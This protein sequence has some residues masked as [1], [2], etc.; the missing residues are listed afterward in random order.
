MAKRFSS[1]VLFSMLPLMAAQSSAA[2][3]PNQPYGEGGELN[4]HRAGVVYS[5]PGGREVAPAGLGFWLLTKS[6][7]VWFRIDDVPYGQAFPHGFSYAGRPILH[8]SDGADWRSP[9]GMAV[10]PIRWGDHVGGGWGHG[11]EGT[12]FYLSIW[13]RWSL[14]H[15]AFAHPE[16]FELHYRPPRRQASDVG[17][18]R[19]AT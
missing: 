9:R 11:P 10:R 2:L 16:R 17:S 18:G 1:L 3:V 4:R 6:K 5:T 12:N 14:Q 19:R 7:K 13:T 15:L 8:I